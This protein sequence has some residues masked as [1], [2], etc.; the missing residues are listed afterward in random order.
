MN[1]HAAASANELQKCIELIDD[2]YGREDISTEDIM[3]LSDTRAQCVEFMSFIDFLGSKSEYTENQTDLIQQIHE[4][5]VAM[6][7]EL[8]MSMEKSI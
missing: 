5:A 1:K 2:S 3:T 7:D 6:I 8:S 4:Y